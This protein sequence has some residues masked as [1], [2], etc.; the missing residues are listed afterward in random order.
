VDPAPL[1]ANPLRRSID[2][3]TPLFSSFYKLLF[4]Q[5]PCFQIYT[6]WPRVFRLPR[7]PYDE[8]PGLF[9][10]EKNRLLLNS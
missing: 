6:S 1:I 8:G 3:F 10:Y 5:P 2:L 9:K 7:A 4:S